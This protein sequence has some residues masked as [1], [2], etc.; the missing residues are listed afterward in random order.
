MEVEIFCVGI[1]ILMNGCT[2]AYPPPLEPLRV[3]FWRRVCVSTVFSAVFFLFS[4]TRNCAF[5][6]VKIQFCFFLSKSH[7]AFLSKFNFVYPLSIFAIFDLIPIALYH[8]KYLLSCIYRNA[9]R[10]IF[11][12]NVNCIILQIQEFV[13][14]FLSDYL[15][16]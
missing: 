6:F 9:L 7:L 8:L 11:C 2:Q 14:L 12:P 1:W 4:S 13:L 5:F 10:S 16:A 3:G 15:R